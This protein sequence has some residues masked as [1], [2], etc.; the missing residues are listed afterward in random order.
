[1][2]RGAVLLTPACSTDIKGKDGSHFPALETSF[3]LPPPALAEERSRSSTKPAGAAS[4]SYRPLS[5]A[6][7]VLTSWTRPDT[8]QA[9]ESFALPPP[10]TRSRKIIQMK[11][12]PPEI[13]TPISKESSPKAAEKGVTTSNVVGA[14]RKKQPSAT[15]V[16]G[17]KIARKTAHSLIE[18][19]RRSKMNEEFAAS[20]EYLRYLEQ[21]VTDLKKNA[22]GPT[23]PLASRPSAAEC[24]HASLSPEIS[25]DNED[26]DMDDAEESP[27][28]ILTAI[29][30][31]QP[32]P[33]F[34][35]PS[36]EPHQQFSY[37]ST[38]NSISPPLDPTGRNLSFSSYS[39]LT[40]PALLP[41]LYGSRELDQEATEALL[42]LNTDRRNASHGRGIS[43]KDLLSS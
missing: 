36:I 29:P 40:S 31:Q 16:A 5:P 18:R 3:N 13:D 10:P 37:P 8:S 23:M 41:Q 25:S 21:C 6:S 12:Q 27:S 22:A 35:S 38:S 14:G 39:S 7:P 19:R 24:Y 9:K 4:A 2:P 11:P 34:N 43:V 42:L 33:S 20:I 1:M 17:R 30:Q 15:S 28:P 26:Q 32:F